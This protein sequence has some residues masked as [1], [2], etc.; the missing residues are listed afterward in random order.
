M[1][2][3][4]CYKSFI[5][6]VLLQHHKLQPNKNSEREK[7]RKEE[8]EREW[9]ARGRKQERGW[10]RESRP[11]LWSLSDIVL[12]LSSRDAKN[13]CCKSQMRFSFLSPVLLL[14]SNEKNWRLL[15][16]STNG[17]PETRMAVVSHT[18]HVCLKR[19]LNVSNC[20]QIWQVTKVCY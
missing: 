17:S 11:A 1:S 8:E 20:A 7:K 2:A 13:H 16:K 6:F 4:V 9:F 18:S 12:L 5:S 15:T 14:N 19:D 3:G 10:T